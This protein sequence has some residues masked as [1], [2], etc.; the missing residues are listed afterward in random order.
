MCS[1]I[2]KRELNSRQPTHQFKLIKMIKIKR[3][4]KKIVI[5]TFLDQK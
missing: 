3:R 5:K 4:I 2:A 1:L